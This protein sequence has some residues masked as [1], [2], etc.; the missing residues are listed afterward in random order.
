MLQER[1][2]T[3]TKNGIQGLVLIL[4]LLGLFLNVRLSIWVAWGIPASFIGMFIIASFMGVTINMISLFGMILVVGIL[5]DDGIVIAENIYKHYENGAEKY[6]AAIDGTMEVFPA[7][8]T[9]VTTTMIAFVPLLL[10]EGSEFIGEMAV[11]VVACL[12]FFLIRGFC[13]ITYAYC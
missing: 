1:I 3:L 12:G 6:K 4:I 2:N 7:V 10:S 13:C 8:F 5:V 9:S 11:V